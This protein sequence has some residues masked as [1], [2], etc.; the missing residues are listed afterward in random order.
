MTFRITFLLSCL[1]FGAVLRADVDLTRIPSDWKSEPLPEAAKEHFKT[2]PVTAIKH[3]VSSDG[4]ST[5]TLLTAKLGIPYTT[6]N[7]EK[8]IEDLKEGFRDN[9]NYPVLKAELVEKDGIRLVHQEKENNKWIRIV[10]LTQIC[11]EKFE[12]IL[13]TVPVAQYDTVVPQAYKLFT[14]VPPPAESAPK[15]GADESLHGDSLEKMGAMTA[16]V[17]I[18]VFV[19]GLLLKLLIAAGKKKPKRKSR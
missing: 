7:F 6:T 9:A 3:F 13:I 16:K 12:Q 8:A 11:P 17:L 4:E 2:G 19:V 18:G 5:L 1:L 14:P 15:T 10:S